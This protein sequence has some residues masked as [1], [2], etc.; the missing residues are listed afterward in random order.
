MIGELAAICNPG[1]LTQ[2]V[3]EQVIEMV[4]FCLH[5][6]LLA[7]LARKTA[8]NCVSSKIPISSS[9]ERQSNTSAVETLRPATRL[10][11]TN[12]RTRFNMRV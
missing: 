4:K 3:K 2:F 5:G 6:R 7:K 9:W 11:D 10:Q 12:L 8:A 1:I